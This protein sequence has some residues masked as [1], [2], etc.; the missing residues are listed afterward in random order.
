M[1]YIVSPTNIK[2]SIRGTERT[3]YTYA[4]YLYKR[5]IAVTILNSRKY[6]SK[7][8][9]PL[10]D[11]TM[12]FYNTYKH[13]PQKDVSFIGVKINKPLEY[14]M[15]FYPKLPREGTVYLPAS[16]YDYLANVVL[17]SRISPKAKFLI[18]EHALQFKNIGN[19]K[20]INTYRKILNAV[21]KPHFR[22][23]DIY[24]HVINKTQINYLTSL[25]VNKHNIFYVPNFINTDIYRIREKKDKFV[26][27]HIG[28]SAKDSY[29]VIDICN[30]LIK[31]GE[32]KKFIFYFIDKNQPESLK[33]LTKKYE[34]NIFHLEPIDQLTKRKILGMSDVIICP[35]LETSSVTM[36]EGLVS[37]AAALADFNYNPFAREV[38][39]LGASVYSMN[40]DDIS[41][42]VDKLL[43]LEDNRSSMN[44][45]RQKDRTLIKDNFGKGIILPRIERMFLEVNEK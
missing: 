23:R 22:K 31:R 30:E 27:L 40:N 41:T 14:C 26:V 2:Y 17:K 34:R 10:N 37:G 24:H 38:R 8:T 42:Y 35:A 20:S 9:G 3:V 4:D 18:G 33:V 28:G 36:L 45:N 7:D 32:I 1:I 39:D 13:I 25:G 6:N 12:G 44:K 19:I 29:R 21:V 15:S 43:Y 11:D 5:G 16:I